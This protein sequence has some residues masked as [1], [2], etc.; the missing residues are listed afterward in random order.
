M[1]RRFLPLLAAALLLLPACREERARPELSPQDE[2][3]LATKADEKIGTI[4]R[5]NLPS[6]FAGLVVFRSDVFL[7]QSALLDERGLSVLNAFGNAAIVLLRSAD[8][9]PLLH[10]ESVKKIYYFSRQ[11][12]LA[13]FH[14]AFEMDLLRR[15][16]E[17][18]EEEPV[19][20]FIRFREVPGEE[21]RQAL[22]A[23]GLRVDARAGAVWTVTGPPTALPRLLE[24]DRI[25]FYEAASKARTM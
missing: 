18:K 5:E 10:E 17:G 2:A 14:P 12:P 11:G 1:T 25:I 19:S 15:F 9:P 20:F 6:L 23:A 24:N 16:G 13:R 21:D 7:T 3:V 4:I 22:T 8:I